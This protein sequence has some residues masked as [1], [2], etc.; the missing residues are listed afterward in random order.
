VS[1]SVTQLIAPGSDTGGTTSTHTTASVA[2]AAGSII[3]LTIWH[4]A[5][6]TP[7]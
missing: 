4:G 3:M 1:V 5:N 2:P 6:E 7:D